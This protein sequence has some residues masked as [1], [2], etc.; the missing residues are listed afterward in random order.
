VG[1]GEFSTGEIASFLTVFAM[2]SLTIAELSGFRDAMLELCV[3]VDLSEFDA[4]DIVGTGGDGKDTFNISTTSAFVIAGAG[5]KVSKHGNYGVSSS[6]GSSNV[7]EHL[8]VQFTN[9]EAKLKQ[10]L[11]TSGFCMMHAPLFHPAMK[12]VAPVR[13]EMKVRTFFNILGPLINPSF[14]KKQFL[15][16]YNLEVFRLYSYLNQGTDVKYSIIHALDG[17]DEIS[18]TGATKIV[19]NQG[20]Y[21]LSP[22][23]LGFSKVKPEELYG[24]AS[25]E[26][27][28]KMLVSI[29]NNEEKGARKNVVLANAGLAIATAKDLSFEEGIAEATVSIESGKA[30]KAL[31]SLID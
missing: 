9:E 18:L 1:Q 25:I 10:Q 11:E 6:C 14:P 20:E 15:G 3:K 28:A 21:L 31:K 24:G 30:Y 2:R 7:L 19:N 12:Y 27:S 13:K 22:E 8:G 29:L 17:Y 23:Q 5:V 26:E 16:V 4:I